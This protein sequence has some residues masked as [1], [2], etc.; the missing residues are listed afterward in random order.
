MLR[1]TPLAWKN[2]THE[3]R[4]MMIAVGGVGFAV[5]LM[6]IEMGFLNALLDSTVEVLRVMRGELVIVSQTKFAMA[7]RERFDVQRVYQSQATPGVEGVYPVYMETMGAILRRRD[8]TPPPRGYPIRVFGFRPGDPLWKIPAVA[9][10]LNELRQPGVALLDEASRRQYG[11]SR[12]GKQ[13]AKQDVELTGRRLRFV[14]TFYLGVDFTNDGNLIMTAENFAKYFPYRLRGSDPLNVVDLALVKLQPGADPLA[15]QKQLIER[16][17]D[18]VR[19]ET[20]EKFIESEKKFWRKSTPIGYIFFVGTVVGF[21]VGVIICYQIIYAD[22]SDHMREFATMKAMGYRTSYFFQLVLTQAACLSVFGFIPGCL[23]A[24]G[25]YWLIACITGLTMEMKL[26]TTV[27][28]LAATLCMCS[29]SGLLAV[30]KLLSA[31][32]AELF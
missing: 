16:L 23:A 14:G 3:P 29:I 32:P 17:P 9:A 24:A 26:V 8:A 21:V 7:A 19:V 31:D 25:V 6:F 4:R 5:L 30:R 2:L 22:I 15:V 11:L 18:D 10:R 12:R 20:K 27:E 13:L 1:K 28:I